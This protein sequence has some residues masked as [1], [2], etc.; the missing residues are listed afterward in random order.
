MINLFLANRLMAKLR[1]GHTKINTKTILPLFITIT[2]SKLQHILA[3]RVNYHPVNFIHEY[4]Y[5]QSL[6][7][8]SPESPVPMSSFELWG[9]R[10]NIDIFLRWCRSVGVKKECM[11]EVD[12]L[13]KGLYN[14]AVKKT[15]I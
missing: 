13:G 7:E 15:M 6:L 11:F 14:N 9:A 4:L 5:F 2:I 8:K 12:G 1:D 3:F 10:N